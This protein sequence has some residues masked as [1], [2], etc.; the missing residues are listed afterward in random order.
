MFIIIA[1][2]PKIFRDITYP[3]VRPG[4]YMISN[5]GDIY[6]KFQNKLLKTVINRDGYEEAYLRSLTKKKMNITVHR[7]VAWEFCDGYDEVHNNVNHKNTVRHYN[8]YENLEW[9][10]PSE[11]TIHGFNHGY[12]KRRGEDS[13]T[14]K[15]PES[16]VRDIK[17]MID[18]GMRDIEI[19]NVYGYKR[20]RDNISLRDLIYGIRHKR[21]WTHI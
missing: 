16:M 1:T 14:N 2:E 11:N 7:L 9:V 21:I 12:I 4:K 13:Y 3:G 20:T 19:M 15:Y 17:N 5:Y 8:Y 10:T 6:S 18:D